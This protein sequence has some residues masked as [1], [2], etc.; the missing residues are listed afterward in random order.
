MSYLIR[1]LGRNW[2]SQEQ[3]ALGD[4]AGAIQFAVP[5]D[6]EVARNAQ[7]ATG[8]YFRRNLTTLIALCRN[9]GATPVFLNE[10]IN[11]SY[12][13]G[14]GVYYGAVVNA[15]IRN[16][17]LLKELAERNGFSYIDLYSRMLD[18]STFVDAAHEN[19]AGMRM[20]ALHVAEAITSLVTNILK[21]KTN[22]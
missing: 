21:Q 12:E 7:T 10:P 14:Q 22:K 9:M 15:V 6:D 13:S 20:K 16:N 1:L 2:V 4:M 19:K 8:K 5:S 17:R 3:F 11:P 18:P